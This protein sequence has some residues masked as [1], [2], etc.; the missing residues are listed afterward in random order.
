M[1]LAEAPE[2]WVLVGVGER[3]GVLEK[4]FVFVGGEAQAGAPGK[5]V[6]P[7]GQARHEAALGAPV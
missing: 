7:A 2:D 1:A 4:V 3:E 6:V 5:E